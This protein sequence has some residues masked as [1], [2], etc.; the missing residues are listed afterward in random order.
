MKRWFLVTL[1]AIALLLVLTFTT[2]AYFGDTM[3]DKKHFSLGLFGQNEDYGTSVTALIPNQYGWIGLHGARHI[4]NEKIVNETYNVHVQGI[5]DINDTVNVE[6]YIELVHDLKRGVE[7]RPGVGYFI[8]PAKFKWNDFLVS[9][10]AGNWSQIRKDDD[11]I[12]R[13]ASDHKPHFGWLT[14]ISGNLAVSTGQL[15]TVVR[16]K[17]TI[18]FDVTTWEFSTAFNYPLNKEWLLGITKN[19]IVED[20]EIHASYQVLFTYTPAEE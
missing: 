8:R 4:A 7:H 2:E 18:D 10:G 19:A 15:S 5:Y 16:Y 14:F 11:L 17:P 13:D 1:L 20:E 3:T 6:G 12:G 9:L